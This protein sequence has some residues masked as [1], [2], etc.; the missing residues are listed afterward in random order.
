MRLK[1]LLPLMLL[2]FVPFV[3]AE[4]FE[5]HLDKGWNMF[6]IPFESLSIDDF[7][8]ALA[9]EGCSISSSVWEYGDGEYVDV[10][11]LKSGEGYWVYSGS[12]CDLVLS[13][14]VN[15]FKNDLSVGWNLVGAPG[16]DY[17]FADLMGKCDVSSVI[18]DWEY[19]SQAGFYDSV[20]FSSEIVP[21]SGYWVYANHDCTFGELVNK[22]RNYGG[23]FDA[24]E[25]CN[26]LYPVYQ[27]DRTADEVISHLKKYASYFNVDGDNAVTQDDLRLIYNKRRVYDN[28][29]FGEELRLSLLIPNYLKDTIKLSAQQVLE[30]IERSENHYDST[31]GDSALD[32][33][34]DGRM[35][36]S[37][38]ILI[39]R[40]FVTCNKLQLPLKQVF[41]VSNE[42]WR[43]VLSLVPVAVWS[44]QE[45]DDSV[46]SRGYGASGDVCVYPL[47]VYHE[48][49]G[50]QTWVPQPLDIALYDENDELI[51]LLARLVLPSS[52]VEKSAIPIGGD[53]RL[54][55]KINSLRSDIYVESLEVLNLPSHLVQESRFIV[56]ETILKRGSAY[57]YPTIK[58]ISEPDDAITLI[59]ADSIIHFMQ[60]YSEKS[61]IDGVTLFGES[62]LELDGLITDENNEYG[63]RL[64]EDSV[65]K[66][67]KRA[68]LPEGANPEDYVLY[69]DLINYYW[70][71]YDSVV[72]VE[73][74]YELA[75]LASTY[76][77]LI[78]VPLIIEGTELDQ[79]KYF[80]GKQVICVG[81]VGRVCDS[82]YS[83]TDL[84]EEY[85][86]KT[87]TNKLIL[88]NPSD[89]DL[90]TLDELETDKSEGDIINLYSKTSLLAPILASAKQELIL[91]VNS[92][93]YVV[94]DD[95]LKEQYDKYVES[96]MRTCNAGEDCSSGFVLDSVPMLIF[97][98]E[99]TYDFV[100]LKKRA[101]VDLLGEA[102]FSSLLFF[103]C[104]D[105]VLEVSLFNNDVLIGSKLTECHQS[106]E[107][108]ASKDWYYGAFYLNDLEVNTLEP[109][110]LRLEFENAK[111]A[112]D[113][114]YAYNYFQ[115]KAVYFIENV[116]HFQDYVSCKFD[117]AAD[118][119][120]GVRN[121]IDPELA[122]STSVEQHVSSSETLFNFDN[123]DASK[124][125][126]L[127][128]QA[129]GHY[130]RSAPL[131]LFGNDNKLGE[132]VFVRAA[133]SG[134]YEIPQSMIESG[135]LQ[136]KF[137]PTTPQ[138]EYN[139]KV[140]LSVVEPTYLTIFA[141][142]KAVP[143]SKIDRIYRYVLN[144][145]LD[146]TEYA[147]IDGDFYPDLYTG[148]IMGLTTSDVSSYLARDLFYSSLVD[149]NKAAFLV[150]NG[151]DDHNGAMQKNGNVA[152]VWANSF[153]A[154]QYAVTC[155]EADPKGE[156]CFPYT[157]L[158][159]RDVWRTSMSGRELI[160]LANHGSTSSAGIHSA[161]I[162]P[163]ENSIIIT[164]SCSTC[165][166]KQSSD[167]KEFGAQSFCNNAIR[168][169]AVGYTGAVSVS[170]GS[171]IQREMMNNLY[172][173][174]KDLG[175]AFVAS[176]EGA[177]AR[178][179]NELIGDP[180]FKLNPQY[181]LLEPLEVG[182][183]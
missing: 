44:Q 116:L 5:V 43:D 85:F 38:L 93:D 57:A 55:V 113:Q 147:D 123:L 111:V 45:G 149:N 6:S 94:V 160:F 17:T 4:D 167:F 19:S 178:W 61:P 142:A 143:Y 49:K 117:Y 125:Y 25:G 136:V 50:T 28:P 52:S 170:Y 110:T 132:L 99:L 88:T 24:V 161:S 74:D 158:N 128:V 39:N 177:T 146:Q 59:D 107:V 20:S 131:E 157:P 3:L 73:D 97:E 124:K 159:K 153:S 122:Q 62:P 134:R 91:S 83:L 129:S 81:V 154:V 173:E 15:F 64:D 89:L 75:L 139:V 40:A 119:T 27:G 68:D 148:R 86:S 2:L 53:Y 60:Q 76:A 118:G 48:E 69:E 51:D 140:S 7:N 141:D 164:H 101:G 36:F 106:S 108:Y 30:N 150:G 65:Q 145:A 144:Y 176:Y 22:K 72:F 29:F 78:N 121:C 172:L 96:D 171:N 34:D 31:S 11:V 175:Q 9:D 77:S 14:D 179:W 79:D 41:V 66:I 133:V 32:V 166:A 98:N 105:S 56:G 127:S 103:D 13:G 12:D 156:S 169:G 63:A 58:S 84:Q 46:C 100:G 152:P 35:D 135:N 120:Y 33:N 47:L 26:V 130:P 10:S 70:E 109:G 126:M 80:E 151:F 71:Y 138:G 95:Y 163:L 155:S 182:W 54:D 42:N 102:I 137:V 18:W 181:N 92:D 112:I 183:K 114:E 82:V 174:N 168:K 1:L 162:P 115:V 21:F 104:D 8:L 67:L 37:D 23:V 180:T 90:K 87:Q 16:K 165:A